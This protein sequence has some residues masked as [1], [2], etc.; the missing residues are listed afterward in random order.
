VGFLVIALAAGGDV[1]GVAARVGQA[2]DVSLHERYG[3]NRGGG[4][5]FSNWSPDV[6]PP[7]VH[8]VSNWSD[9]EHDWMFGDARDMPYVVKLD[10][11]GA[12]AADDVIR[13]LEQAGF[14]C[15]VILVPF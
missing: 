9:E 8:V 5:Y 11:L 4:R 6:V 2:L 7:D 13:R 1:D 12:V 10:R 3:L 15:R 14:A